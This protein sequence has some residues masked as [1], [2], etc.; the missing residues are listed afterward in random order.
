MVTHV[1]AVGH[2]P[3]ALAIA[4]VLLAE[5]K[6]WPALARA[7]SRALEKAEVLE[8]FG[9]RYQTGYY[10]ALR[11]EKRVHHPNDAPTAD[12]RVFEVAASLTA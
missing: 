12:D 5:R 2:A 1:T 6:R 7:I 8:R 9:T 11:A 10:L 3:R 4:L